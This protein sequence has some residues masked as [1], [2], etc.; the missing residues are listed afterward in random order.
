MTALPDLATEDL[1]TLRRRCNLAADDATYT[2]TVLNAYAK[3]Y[4]LLDRLGTSPQY[5]QTLSSVTEPE[6]T[7]NPYWIATYDLN[8]VAA[9]VWQERASA[10][11]DAFAFS[12]DGARYERQQKYDMYMKQARYYR[13][14]RS[15]GSISLISWSGEPTSLQLP[16]VNADMP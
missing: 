6:F 15:P 11:A 12:A 4:A 8:A 5:I 10:L 3:K 9:D 1:A 14:R 13:S 7:V 16:V 2:N